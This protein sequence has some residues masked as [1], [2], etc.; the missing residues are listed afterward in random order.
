MRLND[1]FA[2]GHGWEGKSRLSRGNVMAACHS[3]QRALELDHKNVQAQQD[4]HEHEKRT[5]ADFVK[6]D[7][8]KAVFCMD[9][10]LEFAPPAIASKSPKQN[11]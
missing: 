11:I 10:A 2:W 6:Q 8:Q 7:F 9:C 1:S 4:I 3:F 5:E